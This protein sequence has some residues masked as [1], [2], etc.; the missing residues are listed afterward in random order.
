MGRTRHQTADASVLDEHAA[1]IM[2]LALSGRGARVPIEQL[3]QLHKLQTAAATQLEV[4]NMRLRNNMLQSTCR[5]DAKGVSYRVQRLSLQDEKIALEAR[6]VALEAEGRFLAEYP[7]YHNFQCSFASHQVVRGALA[8]PKTTVLDVRRIDEILESGFLKTERQWV[9]AQCTLT[10]CPLLDVAAES[11]IPDKHA[12]VVVY[13]A[14]GKRAEKAKEVLES[15]GYV[16]VLNAGGLG[17]LGYL[18]E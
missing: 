15:K 6:L 18:K 5:R 8:N 16:N 9:H 4:V 10:E 2:L 13:C 12:P 1:T 11:L 7:E 14:S 17:D 3:L